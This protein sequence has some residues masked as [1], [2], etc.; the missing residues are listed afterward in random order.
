MC[1]PG[2]LLSVLCSGVRLARG[3]AVR[4]GGTHTP[5]GG[6]L[7][8]PCREAWLVCRGTQ[9][10]RACGTAMWP[11]ACSLGMHNPLPIRCGQVGARAHSRAHRLIQKAVAAQLHDVLCSRRL[12]Q[13]QQA[14]TARTTGV[15]G[16]SDDEEGVHL[17]LL[18]L[19]LHQTLVSIGKTA[20]HVNTLCSVLTHPPTLMV[21]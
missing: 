7:A 11:L 15:A 13:D 1:V 21:T 5:A 17:L 4:G 19:R 6:T 8:V 3:K 20:T 12:T 16:E 2:E 14:C 18:L 10:C 9:L